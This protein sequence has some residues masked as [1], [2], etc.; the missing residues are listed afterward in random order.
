MRK[1]LLLSGFLFLLPPAPAQTKYVVSPAGFGNKAG[2][3][4]NIYPFASRYPKFVYQQVHDDLGG[5]KALVG[6]AFRKDESNQAAK[7]DPGFS[8]NCTLYLSNTPVRSANAS[9]VFA[10][11]HGKDKTAVLRK[12]TIKFPTRP[13]VSTPPAPFLAA[14]P[15]KKPFIYKGSSVGSLCWELRIH[16]STQ[17]RDYNNDCEN[18][19]TPSTFRRFGS[20][21]KSSDQVSNSLLYYSFFRDL[22]ATT[23]KLYHYARF[24]PKSAPYWIMIGFNKTRLANLVPLPLDLSIYGAAKGNSLYIDPMFYLAGTTD[25]KGM[26]YTLDK[27]YLTAPR[28]SFLTGLKVY[29]QIFTYDR[30]STAALPYVFTNACEN[31]YPAVKP[32]LGVSRIYRFGSDTATSGFAYLNWA[33]VTR[34]TYL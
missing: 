17:T 15:W 32:P 19:S 2:N 16:S 24:N 1:L 22:S 4:Y 18:R 10:K 33:I 12:V 9:T 26:I 27:G 8:F 5:G 30:G 3:S 7:V 13:A 14:I 28:D 11:N 31:P 21:G 34:F 25:V 29:S 20:G 23:L 6:M